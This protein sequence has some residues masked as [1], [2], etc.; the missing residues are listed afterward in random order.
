MVKYVPLLLMAGLET[1]T[2]VAAPRPVREGLVSHEAAGK[3][4]VVQSIPAVSGGP[5]ITARLR[6][7][8]VIAGVPGETYAVEL[9][10]GRTGD[11][12]FPRLHFD[13]REVT[14]P[15]DN[16]GKLA[17]AKERFDRRYHDRDPKVGEPDP[18]PQRWEDRKPGQHS[19]FWVERGKSWDCRLVVKK[20]G[21]V[22][23]DTGYFRAVL[24]PV[25]EV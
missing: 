5:W 19:L 8:Y 9:W 14:I 10:L 13:T 16:G 25:V 1:A 22:L 20:N 2:L 17:E 24:D 12:R 3:A 6:V 15:G 23:S 21:K 18:R 7:N 11:D 4:C